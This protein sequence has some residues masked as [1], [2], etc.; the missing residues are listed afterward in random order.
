MTRDDAI[1]KAAKLLKV[2]IERLYWQERRDASRDDDDRA[3]ALEAWRASGARLKE[4]E[5]AKAARWVE[6]LKADPEYQ[7]LRQ[8]AEATKAEQK[9]LAAR[10][11]YRCE[12]GTVEGGMFQRPKAYGVT[13]QRTIDALAAKLQP[14]PATGDQEA[15]EV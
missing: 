7:R 6:L 8:A 11:A 5:A 2:P 10:A 15:K 14:A 12:L 3:A 9:T 1:R 13:W 4:L